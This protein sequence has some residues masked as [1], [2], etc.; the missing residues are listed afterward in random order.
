MRRSVRLVLMFSPAIVLSLIFQDLKWLLIYPLL[1]AAV[2]GAKVIRGVLKFNDCQRD[3]E[4]LKKEIIEAKTD[5][6]RKGFNF[7]T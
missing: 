6:A 7:V 3:S 1:V 5:L 2:S 4:L